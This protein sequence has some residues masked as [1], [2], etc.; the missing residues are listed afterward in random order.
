MLVDRGCSSVGTHPSAEEAVT[1]NLPL[2]HGESPLIHVYLHSEDKVGVKYARS[3]MEADPEAQL[4]VVSIDGCTPFT[5]KECDGGMVQF[6]TARELVNNITK[7]RL[8]PPHEKIAAPPEGTTAEQLPKLLTT[9]AV[10][11]YY[12]WPVGSGGEGD[13]VLRRIGAHPLLSGGVCGHQLTSTSRGEGHLLDHPFAGLEVHGVA[14]HFGD[15]ASVV[16]DGEGLPLASRGEGLSVGEHVGD[17]S[18]DGGVRVREQFCLG[19]FEVVRH[20]RWWCCLFQEQKKRRGVA[21]VR[22]RERGRKSGVWKRPHRTM[23]TDKLFGP[24]FLQSMNAIVGGLV[25]GG[26]MTMA[27]TKWE[28]HA[29]KSRGNT[30][31]RMEG[32]ASTAEGAEHTLPRRATRRGR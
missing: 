11:K 15:H 12:G 1:Q 32:E 27:L 13:E 23:C 24:S 29:Q 6:F 20:R 9:D 26:V 8:V 28:R 31:R 21:D 4:I 22:E 14:R 19:D 17:G 10:A 2:V 7:H 16:A 3:V 25:I 30:L 5:R 18:K